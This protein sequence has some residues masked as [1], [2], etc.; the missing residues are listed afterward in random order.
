M[1]GT[2][3]GEARYTVADL[4]VPGVSARYFGMN[5]R[6]EM[7]GKLYLDDGFSRAFRTAPNQ[8]VNPPTDDLDPGGQRSVAIAI[9]NVG[10]VLGVWSPGILD[11][12][13]T[14]GF[15]TAPGTAISWPA[16]N[17]DALGIYGEPRAI[18]DLGQ[19]VGGLDV[20]SMGY[21]AFRTAP[22]RPIDSATDDLGTL[23]GGSSFAYAINASGQVTGSA[24]TADG[25][26]HA[27]RT[28]P[29]QP[30]S[31]LTDDLGTLGGPW[32]IG[33]AVNDAGQVAGISRLDG[34]P[35][36]VLRIFRTA[37]NAPINPATD[38]LGS[39]GNP[40]L[41]RPLIDMNNQG[42]I[43]GTGEFWVAA[44]NN[45]EEKAFVV[46]GSTMYL[47]DDLIDPALGWRLAYA[48]DINNLGQ[49]IAWGYNDYSGGGYVLLN[50]IP[51]PSGLGLV[52]AAGWMMLR[53][54]M[55]REA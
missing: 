44:H 6:G 14:Y 5:D 17:L 25:K 26:G 48:Y 51:E 35:D 27:F 39:F 15:R 49:I 47:L 23:G 37:P 3:R 43:V 46:L 20:G 50:P 30:I 21:H 42:D 19:V 29:N 8:P 45:N 31:P 54:R 18:N 38:D 12:D 11:D 32:S 55:G 24:V 7:V 4:S 34:D 33:Y 41:T 16:D 28:A 52:G 9:N 13:P 1:L 10:Q 53:R 36:G 2:A 22:N 40:Y